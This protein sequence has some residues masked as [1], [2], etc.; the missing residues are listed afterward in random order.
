MATRI[1][2]VAIV[3]MIKKIQL[4]NLGW[5]IIFDHPTCS[6]W[7]YLIVI[8]GV[9]KFFQLPFNATIESFGHQIVLSDKN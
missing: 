8:F 1:N 3:T 9:I 5:L 2:L 4:P 7:N 6:N